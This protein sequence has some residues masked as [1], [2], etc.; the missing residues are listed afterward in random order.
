ME[1]KSAGTLGEAIRFHRRKSG[2]SQRGLADLAQIGKTSV[3]DIE[4][5]KATTR[6][7]TL[8]AVLKVLNIRLDLQ[9]PLV[10]EFH[11]TVNENSAREK[12]S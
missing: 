2:L 12:Q 5:G 6:L 10:K 1:I 3:F 7:A 11:A 8:L 4:K 9:S